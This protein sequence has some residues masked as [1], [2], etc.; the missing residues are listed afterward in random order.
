MSDVTKT[1]DTYLE[2]AVARD[3][4]YVDPMLETEGHAALGDMVLDVGGLAP[5]GRL[6][7]ITG[8]FGELP[9]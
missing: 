7:R 8:F 4:R 1:V 3:G 9:E 5:D 2:R 6:S